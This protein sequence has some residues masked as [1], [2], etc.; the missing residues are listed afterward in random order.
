MQMIASKMCPLAITRGMYIAKQGSTADSVFFLQRGTVEVLHLGLVVGHISAPA[1]F[2]EVAI[3]KGEIQSAR[4]RLSGYR[5]V[6]TCK[7]APSHLLSCCLCA[8][9]TAAQMTHVQ[10]V[11]SL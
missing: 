1:T 2:G 11:T 8:R 5:S 3:L 9:G 6:S 4:K 10:D 7:N